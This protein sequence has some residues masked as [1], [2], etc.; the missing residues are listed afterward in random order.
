M[1]CQNG[2]ENIESTV[3]DNR[4]RTNMSTENPKLGINGYYFTQVLT[5]IHLLYVLYKLFV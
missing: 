2:R 5:T 3:T 1:L 4:T